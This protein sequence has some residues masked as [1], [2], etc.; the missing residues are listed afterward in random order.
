VQSGQA[1]II[2]RANDAISKHFISTAYFCAGDYAAKTVDALA[3]FRKALS[4][5]A[6]YANANRSKMIPLLVAYSGVEAKVLA[7]M[8]PVGAARQLESR[9]IQ[10]LIDAALKY[11]SIAAPFPA[12][13]MID[14]NAFTT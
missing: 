11:K 12:K 8:P 14:P 13:E 6:T 9:L 2:G 1:Q 5:S 4:E 3:R 7:E 10:P